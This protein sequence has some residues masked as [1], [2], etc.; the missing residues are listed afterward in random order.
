MLNILAN[1]KKRIKM[2]I[3]NE[4]QEHLATEYISEQLCNKELIMNQI[5]KG[6]NE[7]QK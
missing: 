1:L 2:E 4:Q 6:E 3:S 5:K 7:K